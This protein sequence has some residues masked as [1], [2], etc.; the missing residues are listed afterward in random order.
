[1]HALPLPR[2]QLVHGCGVRFEILAL[3]DTE[4]EKHTD[5]LEILGLY[6]LLVQHAGETDV[7]A[8]VIVHEAVI[9]YVG[10]VHEPLCR[11]VTD[12]GQGVDLDLL[13]QHVAL[14]LILF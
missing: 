5:H 11:R 1:M 9:H 6:R 12:L 2:V 14:S 8:F 10:H 7:N 3:L 4:W 13:H